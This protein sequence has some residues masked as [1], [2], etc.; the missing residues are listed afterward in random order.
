MRLSRRKSGPVLQVYRA[1]YFRG[2]RNS[3]GSWRYWPRSAASRASPVANITFLGSRLLDLVK[4]SIDLPATPWPGSAG[5]A[6]NGLL[7]FSAQRALAKAIGPRV[8]LQKARDAFRLG[9]SRSRVRP[10][11]RAQAAIGAIR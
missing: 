9:S 8:V 4:P 11:L 3:S 7:S 2:L 6:R 1:F 5:N 10:P